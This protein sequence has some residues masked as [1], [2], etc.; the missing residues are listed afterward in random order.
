MITTQIPDGR[1]CADPRMGD[2]NGKPVANVRIASNYRVK[3]PS[4]GEWVSEALFFDVA[5]WRGAET[6]GQYFAKGSPII[7]WGELR[8]KKWTGQDG[9]E[10]VG[11]EIANADW[12]FPPKND[13]APAGQYQPAAAQ[14]QPLA[15]PPQ[16]PAPWQPPAQQ[17]LQQQ[18]AAPQYAQPPMQPAAAPQATYGQPVGNDGIPF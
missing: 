15:A 2:A 6:V 1:L 10:H 4:T 8:E 13:G 9:I 14:Q 7:V 12:A 5:L 18:A 11:L 17:P 3:D 16:Q